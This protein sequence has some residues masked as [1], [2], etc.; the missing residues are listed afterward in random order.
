MAAPPS[1]RGTPATR[2][3]SNRR[4]SSASTIRGKILERFSPSCPHDN[5]RLRIPPAPTPRSS[6]TGKSVLT[7]RRLSRLVRPFARSS[8]YSCRDRRPGEADSVDDGSTGPQG[9][10]SACWSGSPEG[11]G[12]EP[13]CARLM[14]V[15]PGD[16]RDEGWRFATPAP[17]ACP[18]MSSLHRFDKLAPEHALRLGDRAGFA[19]QPQ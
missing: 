12:H 6:A 10:D 16:L 5:D 7:G 8:A 14:N 15:H 3:I 2:P 11:L 19:N 1:R 18:R 9:K 4:K 17:Q 13:S